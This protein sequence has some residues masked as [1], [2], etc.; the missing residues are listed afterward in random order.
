[1]FKKYV[2]LMMTFLV[3]NL[4]CGATIFASGSNEKDDAKNAEKVKTEISKLGS[5]K[6]AKI[7]VKQK[8]GTKL[9]GYV[10]QINENNF[11]VVDEK[12][13][14]V[15]EVS[16]PN[17]KQI[18]GHHVSTGV[19]VAIVVGIVVVVVFLLSLRFVGN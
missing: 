16:Y 19:K 6:D 12:T 1:M 3:I 9:K 2:I 8:D 10:S 18:K 4:S 5:G 14:A 11:V 15:S 17:V 13:G 7:E